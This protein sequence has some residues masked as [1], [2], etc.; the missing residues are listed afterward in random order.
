MSLDFLTSHFSFYSISYPAHPDSLKVF[1][2]YK[3]GR[4]GSLESSSDACP[5]IYKITLVRSVKLFLVIVYS[6]EKPG[7]KVHVWQLLFQWKSLAC[8]KCMFKKL[9]LEQNLKQNVCGFVSNAM[10]LG[11]L[12][13]DMNKTDQFNKRYLCLPYYLVK[14]SSGLNSLFNF[15]FIF[16]QSL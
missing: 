3:H 15:M 2:T 10:P 4:I 13:R 16:L 14:L 5:S 6:I 12:N 9:S 1:A 7:L 11:L 8:G